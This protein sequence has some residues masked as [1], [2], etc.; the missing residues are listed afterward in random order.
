MGNIE[1]AFDRG[2]ADERGEKGREGKGRGG[3]ILSIG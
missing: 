3:Q 1:K 2:G